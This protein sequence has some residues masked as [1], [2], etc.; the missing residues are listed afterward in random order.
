VALRSGAVQSAMDAS[1]FRLVMNVEQAALMPVGI[2]LDVEV[3][4]VWAMTLRA[5][6]AAMADAVARTFEKCM[7]MLCL[8]V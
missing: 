8:Y 2:K 1:L 4:L 6:T 5:E 7:L 3:L